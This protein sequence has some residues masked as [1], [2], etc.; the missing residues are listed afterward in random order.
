MKIIK[1]L[2]INKVV[3]TLAQGGLVIMPTETV[4]GAMVDATNPKAVTKLINYKKRPFGK[5][6]SIAVTDKKMAEEFAYLNKTAKDLYKRFLPGPLTIVSKGRGVVA[7]GV[8]SEE[9]TLGIRIPDHKLVLSVI[10][11][12]GKPVTATS[13]NS[14]YQKRPY[15]ISDILN[16]ISTKQKSLIDLIVDAGEL[17]KREPSTVIDTTLDD[18]PVLRQGDIKFKKGNQILSLNEET[19]QNFAKELWQKYES[20]KGKRPIVFALEGEMGTG[21]TVFTKG[22]A[23]A[24]GIKEIVTSPTFSIENEY[25]IP[26]SKLELHHFDAWRLMDAN[27]MESLGFVALMENN[28]IVAIEWAEKVESLIRQFDDQAVIVW[29][30]LEYGKNITERRIGWQVI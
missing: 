5:P 29:V 10:K 15:K 20:Y 25:N 18:S 17:P 4:Y 16:T 13:A 26:N 21:K 3:E 28:A 2:N 19:T 23:R 6:F 14:S 12:L 1:E 8:E 27:E 30:K 11:K 22:L 7:P 9:G 24:I